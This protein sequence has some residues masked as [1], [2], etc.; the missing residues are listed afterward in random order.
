MSIRVH[1]TCTMALR[2]VWVCTT[3]AVKCIPE[4]KARANTFNR[5]HDTNHIILLRP[6]VQITHVH[7]CTCIHTCTCMYMHTVSINHTIEC[8]CTYSVMYNTYTCIFTST[9]SQFLMLSAYV[10]SGMAFLRIDLMRAACS[11]MHCPISPSP[12]STS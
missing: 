4:G 11:G 7:V 12:S 9:G 2:G 5:T 10:G 8:T 6:M 3:H 1:V